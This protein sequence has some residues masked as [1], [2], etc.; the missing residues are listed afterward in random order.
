MPDDPRARSSYH[1]VGHA[2]DVWIDSVENRDLFEYCRALQ[3]V[4]EHL[5]CGLYPRGHHV[6][7][8]IRSRATIWVDRSGTATA[9]STSLTP[10]RGSRR[11]ASDNRIQRMLGSSARTTRKVV[12]VVTVVMEVVMR[13][14]KTRPRCRAQWRAARND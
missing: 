5:G 2:A 12:I 9:P 3:R 7:V 14:P 13:G 1:Q 10:R 11:I 6:H 4:G 8:D